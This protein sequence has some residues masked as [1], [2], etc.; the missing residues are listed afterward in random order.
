[1]NTM[2]RDTIFS[3]LGKP[4]RLDNARKHISLATLRLPHKIGTWKCIC[5]HTNSI[6]HLSGHLHPL[7]IMACA[8]DDCG[9]TWHPSTNPITP[10]HRSDLVVHVRL[11]DPKKSSDEETP[12]ILPSPKKTVLQ[13]IE[14]GA[15]PEGYGYVCLNEKCG[16]SWATRVVKEWPWG[17]G[18]KILAVGGRRWKGSCLCGRWVQVGGGFA[19][20]EVVRR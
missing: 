15:C 9:L 4:T 14:D 17:S 11:P 13:N 7:G 12:Y 20:F 2:L 6:Y 18:R 16:L 10:H 5:G 1:T 8:R 19:V 3:F